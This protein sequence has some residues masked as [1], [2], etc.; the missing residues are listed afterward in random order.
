MTSPVFRPASIAN[1]RETKRA[2]KPGWAQPQGRALGVPQGPARARHQRGSCCG[3]SWAYL[4]APETALSS[5]CAAVLQLATLP[6]ESVHMVVTSPPLDGCVVECLRFE[7]EGFACCEDARCHNTTCWPAT[8]AA[9]RVDLRFT[10]GEHRQRGVALDYQVRQQCFENAASQRIGSL[11][12]KQWT[13]GRG[14]WLLAV[15]V[16]AESLFQQGYRPFVNHSHL[17][18][19][20]IER[21]HGMRT[22]CLLN[23]DVSLAVHEPCKV[24]DSSFFHW[25]IIPRM[26]GASERR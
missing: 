24:S 7:V 19:L 16:A 22:R 3:S 2:S 10:Q 13:S 5:S 1:T 6:D 20:V 8:D 15:V 11:P 14:P 25:S 17:N 4:V 12:A 23:S 18:A 9:K 21:T 26:R